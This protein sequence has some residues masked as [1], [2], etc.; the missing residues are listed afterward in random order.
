MPCG[1]GTIWDQRLLTCNHEDIT[2]CVTGNYEDSD[3]SCTFPTF[4]T[5]TTTTRSPGTVSTTTTP[6]GHV[7][8]VTCPTPVGLFPH[9]RECTEWVHC[10]HNIPYVKDC[11]AGL[12]FNA[13]LKVCDW[14]A[15]A[16]CTSRL[17]HNCDLPT[18][19][20]TIPEPNATVPTPSPLCD[21]EC[22]HK[23]A[24]DCT[25]YYYCDEHQSQSYHECSD[26]LVFHPDLSTCVYANMYP[27]CV[28]T[29]PPPPCLC[30]CFYPSEICTS[31]YHCDGGTPVM[32]DCPGGLYWNQDMKSCD[33]PELVNCTMP[34]RHH[35]H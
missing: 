34:V 11:P 15:S 8:D 18:P 28:V 35:L 22:C 12:H 21:C 29:E 4:T 33:L 17:D 1:K 19:I 13:Q 24:E 14:P 31:L 32:L 16:G 30:N 9:P 3:G 5:T 10:D 7:C 6:S 20:P 23:P 26:G 2:P 25:A 27:E